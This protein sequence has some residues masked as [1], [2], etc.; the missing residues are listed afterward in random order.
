MHPNGQPT[1]HN[2]YHH[3]QQQQQQQQQAHFYNNQ[4]QH[5]QQHYNVVYQQQHPHRFG[6]TS[7][8]SRRI[9]APR[10]ISHTTAT[11]SARMLDGGPAR[12]LHRA[13][14]AKRKLSYNELPGGGTSCGQTARPED[15]RGYGAQILKPHRGHPSPINNKHTSS[16]I[17]TNT[18]ITTAD[19][20]T[21]TLTR[22]VSSIPMS[23]RP[24]TIDERGTRTSKKHFGILRHSSTD[25]PKMSETRMALGLWGVV[26]SFLSP[27]CHS[28]L[29]PALKKKPNLEP[30]LGCNGR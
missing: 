7:A 19:Y 27:R 24:E 16:A 26:T 25:A 18:T 5:Q 9:C 13:S 21:S 22:F 3:L 6:S 12:P 1:Y 20:A 8:T 17:A 28:S 29:H 30:A 11:A 23:N 15:G 10:I 2:G 14:C 4:H